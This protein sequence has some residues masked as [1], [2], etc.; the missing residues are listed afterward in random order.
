[1]ARIDRRYTQDEKRGNEPSTEPDPEPRPE[2]ER[3]AVEDWLDGEEIETGAGRHYV[4]YRTWE[5]HRRHG[6]MDIASLADLPHDLLE[7][8]SE[9]T[10]SPA[11]PGRWCFLDTET[12]GLAGGSGTYAFLIGVG[13]LENGAFRVKQYFLREP[14][15]ESSALE[16]LTEHL[17]RFDV[18]ITYNGKTF[19]IPLLETRY[20]MSR[21]RPPFARMGHLDLLHGA[22]RLW[23]LRFDNCRL[24]QLEN[25][26]LGVERQGDVPGELIPYLYF[27]YL[28]KGEIFRLVPVFHHNAIDVL[29]LACLTAIVP[30]AFRD[31]REAKLFHGTEM[32]GLARWLWKAERLEEAVAWMRQSLTRRLPDALTYRAMWDIAQLER[33]LGRGHMSLAM[34]TELASARNPHQAQ[35]LEELAKHYEHRERN[36]AMALEFTRQAITVSDCPQLRHRQARLERKLAPRLTPRLL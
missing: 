3:I 21:M 36:C 17:S 27:D 30:W 7:A 11:P 9:G 26:I 2:P 6:S 34:Y 15:E 32:L 25:Q 20:R 35:A 5:R 22:R 19:D 31:P 1:M 8:V 29:T 4:T 12:T 10:V 24:M 14:G 23:K 16:A 13:H 28:R 18:I 33:K